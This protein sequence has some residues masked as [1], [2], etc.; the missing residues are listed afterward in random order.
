MTS[1]H[2]IQA[3]R[4][5]GTHCINP[6]LSQIT[7]LDVLYVFIIAV[8]SGVVS[9]FIYYRGLSYTKASVATLAE[10]GFPMAAVIV[11]WY[12]LKDALSLV[13]LL[14]MAILLFAVL[15]LATYN[16]EPVESAVFQREPV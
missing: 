15:K 2:Q 7:A 13:Q 5:V 1:A 16:S 3:P 6:A 9:L 14:G 8:T 12:F 4:S 11:N 10:L